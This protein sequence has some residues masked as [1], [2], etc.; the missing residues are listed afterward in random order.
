MLSLAQD[1]HHHQLILVNISLSQGIPRYKAQGQSPI[2]TF[3]SL[4]HAFCIP[5]NPPMRHV[6]ICCLL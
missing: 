3:S 6:S 1:P 4:P 5:N 2:L